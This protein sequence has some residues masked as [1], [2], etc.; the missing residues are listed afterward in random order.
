M[1]NLTWCRTP[2]MA[3]LLLAAS[4]LQA[5]A[6]EVR[7]PARI[8]SFALADSSRYEQ[9]EMGIRYAYRF[10]DSTQ[11][12]AATA[13][14]YP[15][16]AA[17]L[18]TPA[19]QQIAEEARDFVA[20][21]DGGVE[22]GWYRAFTVVVDTARAWD[23][24]DGSHPGHLVAAILRRDGENLVSF[25]HLMVMGDHYVKTRLTLPAEEW[26]TSRAPNFGP[27]L[28]AALAPPAP[29]PR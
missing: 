24:A 14:V 26:R 1:P 29:A 5:A 16:P 6:Q 13:F 8:P 11:H 18:A 4:V 10:A 17:R 15:V 20:S 22:Q 21:L 2:M 28:F 3:V 23:A 9:P 19:E 7:P 12:V 27:D 25:M